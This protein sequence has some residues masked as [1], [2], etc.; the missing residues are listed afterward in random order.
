MTGA[1]LP[2]VF[3]APPY[4]YRGYARL[5]LGSPP[6]G[7]QWIRYGPDLLLVNVATGRI[8]DVVTGVFY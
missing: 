8:A 7:Y 5:G 2:G 4:Y 3:L 1:F 6:P